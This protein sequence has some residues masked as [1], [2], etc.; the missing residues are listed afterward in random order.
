MMVGP[1]RQ[2]LFNNIKIHEGIILKQRGTGNKIFLSMD[3]KWI[4]KLYIV[5]TS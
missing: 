2:F 4:F 3:T 5:E 1:R